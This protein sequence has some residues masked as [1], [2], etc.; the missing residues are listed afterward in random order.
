V[1]K[2]KFKSQA[3]YENHLNSKKY[4]LELAK[5]NEEKKKKATEVAEATPAD[6]EKI[7][8]K[9]TPAQPAVT[10]DKDQRACLF[11]NFVSESIE[12]NLKYMEKKYGFFIIEAKSCIN[13]QGLLKSL[14]EL[15]HVQKKCM[16]CDQIFKSG[17]DC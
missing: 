4:K 5:F 7:E 10:T 2:K 3:A 6:Q 17:R 13:V 14:G 16:S 11:S 15:L 1:T 8:P 12:E 9:K